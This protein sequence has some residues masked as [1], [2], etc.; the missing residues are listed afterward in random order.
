VKSCKAEPLAAAGSTILFIVF[1][2]QKM[3]YAAQLFRSGLQGLNLLAQLSLLG[4]LFA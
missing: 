4:L 1:V 2:I 3:S